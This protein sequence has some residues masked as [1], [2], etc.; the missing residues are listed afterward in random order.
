M[1][2][3][4]LPTCRIGLLTTLLAASF[5]EASLAGMAGS[6]LEGEGTRYVFRISSTPLA[7][8]RGG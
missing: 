8:S 2:V 6:R 4:L 7:G 5:P 3:A 1:K